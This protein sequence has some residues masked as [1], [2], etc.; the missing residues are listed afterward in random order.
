MRIRDFVKVGFGFT[1]GCMLAQATVGAIAL[2]MVKRAPK[3]EE[4]VGRKEETAEE[5]N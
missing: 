1:I 3:K 2:S 4:E 5:S